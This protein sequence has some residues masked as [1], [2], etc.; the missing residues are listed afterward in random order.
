VPLGT[1]LKCEADAVPPASYQWRLD[2]IES[3]PVDAASSSEYTLSSPG[4]YTI[5]CTATNF[6]T[7]TGN[8]CSSNVSVIVE[9]YGG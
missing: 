4:N 7:G 6:L 9:V 5:E 1:I 3:I 8:E 2:S